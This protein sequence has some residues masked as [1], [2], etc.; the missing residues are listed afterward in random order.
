LEEGTV[1]NKA[2][3]LMTVLALWES[4]HVGECVCEWLSKQWLQKVQDDFTSQMKKIFLLCMCM[5]GVCLQNP[6]L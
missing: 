6:K 3:L 1:S 4:F 2:R 5:C